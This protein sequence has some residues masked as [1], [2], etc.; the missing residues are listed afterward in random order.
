MARR[1]SRVEWL[2]LHKVRVFA[3]VAEQQHYSKAAEILHISQPALSVHVR[4]LERHL[5][6]L[7]FERLGR[8]VRLT[9]AGQMV[10]GYAKRL[11]AL[12]RELEEA[13]DDVKGVRAGK[14]RVGASTTPGA[15]LLPALLSSFRQR[16]PAVA[17]T[18]E[19]AN[20]A[21]IGKR[22]QEGELHVGL[23]G[24]PLV[25]P[26]LELEPFVE[27]ELLLVVSPDHR[28]AGRQIGLKE[29]KEEALIV[30]EE[31]SAT[32]DVTRQALAKAGLDIA[33]SLVLGNTEAVKG[34]VAGGLGVA[35][36]SACAVVHE[37][38]SGRLAQC[39]VRGFAIKRRFQ[40]AHQRGR[41]LSA[42]EQAFLELAR[43]MVLES[44]SS[45]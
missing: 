37:I 11:L 12:T 8:G 13:V 35:F 7:L 9:D 15:Y 36:V 27:D 43:A 24:E 2:D 31:G 40:V 28:W 18:V 17:I 14:L 26:E 19:I 16:Y 1:T 29:L 41:R 45:N 4:D 21:T 42:A 10:H 39:R 23:L 34:A 22:I 44:R 3:A 5:G 38:S 20:T 32:D 30:R 6:V 33:P 25:D